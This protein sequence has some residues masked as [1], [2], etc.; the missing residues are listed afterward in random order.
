MNIKKGS[1]FWFFLFWLEHLFYRSLSDDCFWILKILSKE[2]PEMYVKKS[3]NYRF[4]LKK[5]WH[6]DIAKNE[7]FWVVVFFSTCF[8]ER[9]SETVFLDMDNSTHY[10]QTYISF[11]KGYV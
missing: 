1:F 8:V 5:Q 2:D 4:V 11:S 9:A 6:F 7:N 10:I 3:Q